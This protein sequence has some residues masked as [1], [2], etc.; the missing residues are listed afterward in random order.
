MEEQVMKN[1]ILLLI[2]FLIFINGYS[3]KD[4]Y[5]FRDTIFINKPLLEI[6]MENVKPNIIKYSGLFNYNSLETTIFK[7][8][9]KKWY[10]KVDKQWRLFFND[11][12]KVPLIIDTG[13]FK[14]SILWTRTNL[15][16]KNNQEVFE[17][18]LKPMNFT[19]TGNTKYYFTHKE[20]FIAIK[21]HESFF[22]RKDIVLT[23]Q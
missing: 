2:T 6:T 1:K 8:T 11:G 7:I 22:M 20:G 10:L 17:F 18:K 19:M 16:D 13:K 12:K 5:L 9:D 15:K 23:K 3:Q 4:K 21:S 14:F